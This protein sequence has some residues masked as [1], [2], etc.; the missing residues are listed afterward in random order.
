MTWTGGQV[1]NSSLRDLIADAQNWG[2][3]YDVAVGLAE[4]VCVGRG[5][6][7]SFL[8]LG[9]GGLGGTGDRGEG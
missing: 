8:V 1:H 6:S 4:M 5:V 2:A 7:F 9:F 3:E